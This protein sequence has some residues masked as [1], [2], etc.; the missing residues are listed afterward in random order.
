M[1]MTDAGDAISFYYHVWDQTTLVD[2]FRP[3][4]RDPRI[5]YHH[6]NEVPHRFGL[7][8]VGG[9]V[10]PQYFVYQ[11]LRR[12]GDHRIAAHSDEPSLHVLA[13]RAPGRI[14]VLV[15]NYRPGK[16]DDLVTSR[17][18]SLR[19]SGLRP[20][21]TRLSVYRID[22]SSPFAPDDLE[23]LPLEV[24]DT[25]VEARFEP[26]FLSPADSVALIILEELP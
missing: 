12:M 10:R 1:A 23:L 6:W 18:V 2:A 8:G 22:R 7:F 4:F 3:F 13:S 9:E 25:D 14:A 19:F 24:R 5:M 16:P 26:Q 11:M 21:R 15:A 20:G 17:V